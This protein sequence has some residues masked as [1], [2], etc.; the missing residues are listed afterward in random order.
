M[1]D[2]VSACREW[3]ELVIR[4]RVKECDSDVLG[5]SIDRIGVV[6]NVDS[7]AHWSRVGSRFVFPQT[8]VPRSVLGR[9]VWSCVS[10]S[11]SMDLQM[12]QERH[13]EPKGAVLYRPSI[14]SA[15]KSYLPSPLSGSRLRTVP[16]P[17]VPG[18]LLSLVLV[19][20][21]RCTRYA[22]VG[23]EVDTQ[24]ASGSRCVR[25][26]SR[27]A[28]SAFSATGIPIATSGPVMPPALSMRTRTWPEPEPDPN[29]DP[30]RPLQL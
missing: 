8:V 13:L 18:A 29:P 23:G 27:V 3:V 14:F 30:G 1:L 6:N 7:F 5:T 21:C 24:T 17:C 25:R 28:Q 2:V 15:A 22:A 4:C 20:V 11:A 9:E 10:I 12:Q 26:D 16:C 19:I